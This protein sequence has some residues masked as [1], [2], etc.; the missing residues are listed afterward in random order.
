MVLTNQEIFASRLRSL[1]NLAFLP[2]RRFVHQDLGWN[3]RLSSLQA[4]LGISQ[5]KR[6]NDSVAKR[7]KIAEA[8]LSRL[9]PLPGIQFQA[10]FRN[11]NRNGYW[12]VGLTLRDHPKFKNARQAMSALEKAG[13]GTRPFFYPLHQQPL[14][15]RGFAY[16][17][18]GPLMVAQNLGEQGF[19]LP[20]GLGMREE[21]L[22][23]AVEIAGNTLSA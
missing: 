1:R 6:L 19:Y 18:I 4:A 11:G 12:V 8:Y 10:D 21:Q 22:R 9:S 3:M 16:R 5:I 20:N 23:K 7:R 17:T 2:S 15:D 13:I 14:L